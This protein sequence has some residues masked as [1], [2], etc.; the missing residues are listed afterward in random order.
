MTTLAGLF[1]LT[2]K[3][4]IVTGG[5]RGLGLQ[6]AMAL[7]EYGANLVLVARKA[8][9]LEATVAELRARGWPVEGVVADLAKPDTIAGIVDRAL[10]MFGGVDILVNNAGAT[11]GAPTESH[12]I[13][14]W[15]KVVATNLTGPFLLTQEVARRAMIPAGRGSVINVAS[16]EGLQAHHPDMTATI[17]YNATKGGVINMTRA[18][19]A[20]WGPHNIRVNAIAPGYFPSKMTAATLDAHEAHLVGQTPLGKLGGPTDLM[21]PALL[22]ASDAGGHMSGQ[23]LVVD[24]G[25]I[26][27]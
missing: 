19:A 14:G 16:V 9:E 20:E 3:T 13:D 18:L 12:P 15:N 11:W 4:A 7:G 8:A 21:G 10:D 6:V 24:G 25:A 5:S 1:D 27:I 23:I 2:G 26:V 22:L 17:G